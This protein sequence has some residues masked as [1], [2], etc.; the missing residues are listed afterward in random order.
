LSFLGLQ[1][2]VCAKQ[3]NYP[4][5]T[6][7]NPLEKKVNTAPISKAIGILEELRKID[8]DMPTPAGLALLFVAQKPGIC[9]RDLVSLMGTGKSSVSRYVDMLSDRGGKGFISA[10]QGMVDRRYTVLTLTA[11][12]DRVVRRVLRG[13]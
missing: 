7:N 9:Q 3:A 6:P 13:L 5:P 1:R 10:R 2:P 4:P 8:S 11:E 12:G